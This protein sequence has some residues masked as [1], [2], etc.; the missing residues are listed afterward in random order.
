MKTFSGPF[1]GALGKILLLFLQQGGW[2]LLTFR[3]T[4]KIFY[5]LEY[6]ILITFPFR[7]G[8][9]DRERRLQL[10]HSPRNWIPESLFSHFTPFLKRVQK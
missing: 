4:L 9:H 3:K 6:I 10:G 1:L 2:T 8:V 5:E 7:V